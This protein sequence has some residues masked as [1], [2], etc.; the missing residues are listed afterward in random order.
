MNSKN[1][2][3]FE[4]FVRTWNI[5]CDSQQAAAM[6]ETEGIT[7]L[8]AVP[9]SGKTTTLIGRLGYM[10]LGRGI[11][12]KHILAVTYTVS[13][14][15]TMRESFYRMFSEEVGKQIS[16]KTINGLCW[17]IV[18]RYYQKQGREISVC[19]EAMQKKLLRTV[20]KEA[21]K[22]SYP[23]ESD[24]MAVQM[25]I[26]YVK[27]MM[28]NEERIAK[29]Q[30]E[31][32]K[33]PEIFA[34][35]RKALI[36]RKMVDFDDQMLFAYKILKANPD[37]LDAYHNRYRYICVDEAQDTS[38]LQHQIIHLLQTG[39]LFLTGD[40]DQ[41]IFGYRGAYPNALLNIR[42]IYPAARVLKLETNYRSNA[43]ITDAAGR[44]ID[45][46]HNRIQKHMHAYRGTGGT[47]EL[48]IVHS[49]DA[50]IRALADICAE[51]KQ[52]TAVLYRNNE[53]VIPLVDLLDRNNISY[54]LN[55]SKDTFF[56]GRT[57]TDIRTFM[58][59]AG[60]TDNGELFLKCCFKF[61]LYIRRDTAMLAVQRQ[62]RNNSD[63]LDELINATAHQKGYPEYQLSTMK[64]NAELFRD[65]FKKLPGLPPDRAISSL[66]TLGYEEY[67]KEKSLST[68]SLKILEMIASRT[69][70]IPEFLN[71]LKE[72]QNLLGIK[73][74]GSGQQPV[75]LSTIHSAKGMEFERVYLY[76]IIDGILPGE[77]S[78]EDNRDAY[79]EERRLFY[80]G[81]TR[82]KSYLCIFAVKTKDHTFINELFPKQIKETTKRKKKKKRKK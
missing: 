35:Y 13:G 21:G 59:Y 27:N 80:V 33:F 77:K 40:E 37:I 56:T 39:N 4:A 9:G 72:L 44:F 34:A 16:F 45:R 26:S 10:T 64:D 53:S 62:K 81:M 61:M 58:E 82:A 69:N 60:D 46:N 75:I 6:K 51:T 43:E 36:E 28:W 67:L 49:R 1:N 15:R 17:E 12:P 55:Q 48:A 47:T 18:S 78:N 31:V 41:S 32:N 65:V 76:D 2:A 66:K 50:Q 29:E 3:E 24:L 8:L 22:E 23:T 74:H 52:E 71:R 38:F 5:R 68:N 73:E 70:T 30:W 25:Y 57:V 54:V 20:I 19:D 42:R 63:L 11:D 14:T 7:L 79:E